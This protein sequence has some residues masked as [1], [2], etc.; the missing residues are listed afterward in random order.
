MFSERM[1]D[2]VLMITTNADHVYL[3][4]KIR[5]ISKALNLDAGS[6]EVIYNDRNEASPAQGCFE[7]HTKAIR[8]FMSSENKH[9][10]I[11]EDDVFFQKEVDL[12]SI[13]SEV[14][15]DQWEVIYLGHRP[16]IRQKTRMIKT[17]S[18]K[19]M[20]VK[21]NDLHSYIISRRLHTEVYAHPWRNKAID[22][23]LRDRTDRSYAVYPMAA[24]QMGH[25]FGRS[26]RNGA[27]E[28]K[29][30][31]RQYSRQVSKPRRI[32]RDFMYPFYCLVVYC[33]LTLYSLAK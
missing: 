20:K 24:I 19:F 21:T 9:C 15:D 7:A 12:D 30:E 32:L 10:L 17:K 27:S 23:I 28:L 3:D 33:R 14:P 31:Y 5:H 18:D 2:Q 16:L 6:V 1:I 13:I 25:F 11:L 4:H 8:K 29:N 22:N 26:Y